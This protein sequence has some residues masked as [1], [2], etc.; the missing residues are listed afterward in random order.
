MK[1]YDLKDH[2]WRN[3]L[4]AGDSKPWAFG[5][6]KDDLINMKLQNIKPQNYPLCVQK[7]IYILNVNCCLC[8]ASFSL[9]NLI[10]SVLL[11]YL[12]CFS[13]I[14]FLDMY[15]VLSSGPCKS[16]SWRLGSDG[17]V[18]V[19]IIGESD[20]LRSPKLIL[21]EL[22]DK[23]EANP[24]NINRYTTLSIRKNISR[25]KYTIMVDCTLDTKYWFNFIWS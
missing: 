21:S 3:T 22:R 23:T 4:Y 19:C 24:N 17:D 2:Q 6:R 14:D 8:C 1:K 18:H 25:Q 15:I 16:V 20:D 11:I 10:V 5:F 9:F 7:L 12:M 13:D